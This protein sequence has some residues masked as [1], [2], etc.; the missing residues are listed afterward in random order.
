SVLA[1]FDYLETLGARITRL[2]VN[3][4]GVVS[5]KDL[6]NC[7]N[8]QTGLVSVMAANNETGVLQPIYELGTICEAAGALFHTDYSQ[9]TAYMPVNLKS[10]PIH[11]TSFSG[12]KAYGPKGVGILYR[13]LRRPRVNLEPILKGG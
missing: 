11:L 10:A 7:I 9:A 1:C 4:D 8:A 13:S 6:E 3:E 12:H 5:T 2:P